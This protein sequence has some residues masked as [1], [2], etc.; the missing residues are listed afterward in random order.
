M[1]FWT[2]NPATEERIKRYES[3][4]YE[5]IAEKIERTHQSYLKWKKT[6]FSQ[7]AELMLK[8]AEVLRKN[9]NEYA[10]LMALEMGKP[11]A[12]GIS[13]VEKC[14]VCCEYYAENAESFLQDIAYKTEMSKS[15]VAFNPIGVVLAVMPWNFP[16]WQVF[17]FAA[18]ALMAG[19]CGLLK[20]S[21]NTAGCA[22]A[23]E[24]VLLN[25]HWLRQLL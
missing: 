12:Q 17:R 16:F 8:A 6:S 25:I 14:A 20:H 3:F 7:R 11:L 13:E 24:N 2:I 22:V 4:S 5:I 9:K 23:I 15:Y 19:N 18:P 1:E 10:K 21:R